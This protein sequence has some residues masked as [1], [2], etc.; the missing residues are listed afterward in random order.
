MPLSLLPCLATAR[1]LGRQ[2]P[3]GDLTRALRLPRAVGATAASAKAIRLGR[4]AWHGVS[5]DTTAI[6]GVPHGAGVPSA[7]IE[8]FFIR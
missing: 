4:T 2:S 6:A 7:D 8:I 5:L 1:R 3:S